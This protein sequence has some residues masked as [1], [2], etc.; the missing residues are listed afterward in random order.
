MAG[1]AGEQRRV[2]AHQRHLLL[3]AVGAADVEH[4][5]LDDGVGGHT[6]DIGRHLGHAVGLSGG[7]HEILVV[8]VVVVHYHLGRLG[9]ERRGVGLEV[10]GALVD[11]VGLL[12]G[13]VAV[14][15]LDGEE[16]LLV[17]E[18]EVL[19]VAV[20]LKEAGIELGGAVGLGLLDVEHGGQDLVV[21]LD[22]A[23]GLLA[24]LLGL[25]GDEGDAV[26]DVAQVLVADLLDRGQAL[27]ELL[28][29]LGLVLVGDDGV[30][31]GQGLGLRR[32][33]V[34]YHGMRIG[35]GHQL[36]VQHVLHLEVVKVYALAGDY[37][38]GILPG[39]VLTDMT[40]FGLFRS[41][42]SSTPFLDS[43]SRASSTW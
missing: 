11:V 42:H 14:A 5:A 30:D 25:G 2:E 16:H 13:L 15:A 24:E 41:A 43:F 21:D 17:A 26:A 12:A 6:A 20:V 31:A 23:D 34:L 7:P 35:A 3:V 8:D 27:Q 19:L 39:A 29:E 32:V 40:V 9:G 10:A 18:A 36:G 38:A 1:Q 33:D 4:A 28:G 37:L 22:E